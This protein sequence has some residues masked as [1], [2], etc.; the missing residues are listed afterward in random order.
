MTG[1]RPKPIDYALSQRKMS[2]RPGKARLSSFAP[3]SLTRVPLSSIDERLV[4]P[5]RCSSP[6]SLTPVPLRSS[7]RGWS[8]PPD[9]RTRRR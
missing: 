8:T 5:F 7:S 9:P 2:F 6:A 1:M 4:S 3:A